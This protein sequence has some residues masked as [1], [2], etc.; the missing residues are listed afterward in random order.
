MKTLVRQWSASRNLI[1]EAASESGYFQR[2]FWRRGHGTERQVDRGDHLL[3][4]EA[5]VRIGQGETIG[6][7]CRGSGS[8]SRPTTS[9]GVSTAA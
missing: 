8:R 6:K 9:G 2:P 5:E 1:P 3:L 7:V 4:R